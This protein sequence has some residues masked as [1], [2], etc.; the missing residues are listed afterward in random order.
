MPPELSA[1]SSFIVDWQARAFDGGAGRDVRMVN[2]IT[3]ARGRLNGVHHW[4]E[5]EIRGASL[6]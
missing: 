4:R 2:G 3:R 6:A 1:C 5:L